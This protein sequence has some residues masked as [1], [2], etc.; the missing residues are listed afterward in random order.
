[1][2]QG[3]AEFDH[4]NMSPMEDI[5]LTEQNSAFGTKRGETLLPARRLRSASTLPKQ[6]QTKNKLPGD[7]VGND[8]LP[9]TGPFSSRLSGKGHNPVESL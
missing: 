1:L 2:L 9:L 5:L 8:C 3:L 6:E 4:D 7:H